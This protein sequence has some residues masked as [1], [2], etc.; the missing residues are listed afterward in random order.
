MI[1]SAS[2]DGRGFRRMVT[3]LV[4][5]VI[6]PTAL[7]LALGIVT[8]V[9]WER[10][11]LLFA[12]LVFTLVVCLVT[13]A[14]ILLVLVRREAKLSQLQLDFVSKVSH[15]LRTPLTSIR[16]F[17]EMLGATPG[18]EAQTA[19]CLDVLQRETVRLSERIERLLDWG[20][21]EAGRRTYELSRETVPGVVQAALAAF[22]TAQVGRIPLIEEDVPDG[23][24]D[25]MAD[26][27]A[28][29][30]A[31]VN[32]LS[33]ALKYGGADK[34]IV[35]A[36][37]A[38]AKTVRIAVSDFGIGIP[39]GEHRRIFQKFYR[40]DDRLSREVEGSG[41]GLAIVRH[42][43]LGHG[44]RVEVESAPGKGSTFTL[45]LPVAPLVSE[46][47]GHEA[48]ARQRDRR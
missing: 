47:R 1:G 26:R 18:D 38:S 29:V 41:L 34:R 14:V 21:M 33:N 45:V 19:V 31:L 12:I 36:V 30:D 20:R 13:G 43:A 46:D 16:M 48:S 10:L 2:G 24:P 42:V 7:L 37:R 15:E 17:A 25:V 27:E 3:L 39:V 5:L 28:M 23:T 8:L 44:G 32:L 11:K 4:W 9:Y 6:V 40:I 22:A 35:V